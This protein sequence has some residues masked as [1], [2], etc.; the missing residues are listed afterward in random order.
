MS[1]YHM[2]PLP[3]D[4][5]EIVLFAVQDIQ[6]RINK[7]E[8]L[9]CLSD[10][11]E[12]NEDV[13]I[14]YNPAAWAEIAYDIQAFVKNSDSDEEKVTTTK[15][16]SKVEIDN[17]LDRFIKKNPSIS[18]PKA[19]FYKP[20]NM[21]RKSEEFH[22]E[23]VSETLAQL[24]YKQGHLHTSLEMYEKLMLQNPD[25][26]DIFAARIKSLKEELINKL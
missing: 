13:E 7:L 3:G 2:P 19:E 23:V 8:E 11:E 24:F 15:S 6:E 22:G 9:L 5:R 18:R 16:N 20:E 14:I 26:K 10:E 12:E 25:K 4:M 21:A 17:L 1:K